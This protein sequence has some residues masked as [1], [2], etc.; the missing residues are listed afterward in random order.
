MRRHLRTVERKIAEAFW[1]ICIAFGM[2]VAVDHGGGWRDFA[3][4]LLGG[5][6]IAGSLIIFVAIL[7][8][9]LLPD[10]EGQED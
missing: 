10:D 9:P 8:H 2:G 1:L 7:L 3:A 6:L 4:H 5:T